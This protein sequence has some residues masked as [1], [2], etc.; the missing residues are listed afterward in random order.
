MRPRSASEW[1]GFWRAG[2][3]RQLEALLEEVWEPLDRVSDEVRATHAERVALLLGS[4]APA[5]ALAAE[6]GRIR[7]ELGST[8]DPEADAAAAE[9]VRAWF[10]AQAIV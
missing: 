5:R 7:D 10:E 6:L 9:A 2:G 1:R 8:P 3:E 4:A